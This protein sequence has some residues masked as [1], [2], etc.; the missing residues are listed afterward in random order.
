[1]T[2]SSRPSSVAPTARDAVT[3]T[4][5][6]NR[7]AG[8]AIVVA[9][10]LLVVPAL[11]AKHRSSVRISAPAPAAIVAFRAHPPYPAPPSPNATASTCA[12]C[13]ELDAAAPRQYIEL[14]EVEIVGIVPREA[15][16]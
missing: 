12:L 15:R 2:T 14:D 3:P 9:A 8:V 7:R 11:V 10:A 13:D 6:S 5:H 16:R 4:P 1:M